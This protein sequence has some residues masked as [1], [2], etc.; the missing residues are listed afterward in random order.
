MKASRSYTG[1]LNKALALLVTVGLLGKDC[2]NKG[3][4]MRE[5]RFRAWDTVGQKFLFPWP[6][7][8]AILGETTCFDI[9][10]MQLHERTP[11]KSVLEMLND[12]EI[13]QY[14]GL[15]DREGKEIWEG[16]IVEWVAPDTH[17]K[18]KWSDN[19]AAFEMQTMNGRGTLLLHIGYTPDIAVIGNIYQD[20]HLL[21]KPPRLAAGKEER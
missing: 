17:M 9:I 16:D 3:G 7:G 2:R 11:D 15:K 6:D 5:L 4:N 10:G 1:Y 20:S 21:D 13:T 14:T 18:I 8:F 19:S 12:V